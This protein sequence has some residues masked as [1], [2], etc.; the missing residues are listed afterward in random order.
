[1]AQVAMYPLIA[2]G[3]ET[4]L[5]ADV[6]ASDTMFYLEDLT[7]IPTAPN[8]I[9][10]KTSSALWERCRYTA[11]VVT[12]GVAGY[13]TV[14]RSGSYHASSASGDAALSWGPGA[15]VLR[16]VMSSDFSSIQGNISDHETRMVAAEDDI[17]TTAS[18]LLSHMSDVSN[19]HIEKIC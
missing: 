18:E 19:P 16:A 17:D 14:E 10:I 5:T 3:K 1:M 9:T 2:G 13:I 4:L 7:Y 12:S 11:R 8:L 15:K 6:T